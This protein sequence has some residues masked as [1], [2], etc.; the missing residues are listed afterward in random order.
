MFVLPPITGR[1]H[2]EYRTAI[3][4]SSITDLAA[5]LNKNSVKTKVI[6]KPRIAFL[7]TGQGSQY[8]GMGKEL[9]E[10][11]PGFRAIIDECDRIL[12]LYLEKPLLEILY[13]SS[14]D[15]SIN[16]TK[17]TQTAIFA[18]EYALCKLWQSWGIN[19]E[20]VMGHSVGEYV[21]AT[22][23]GVF[24]LEDGLKLIAARGKLMQTL[25]PGGMVAVKADI[26]RVEVA[27]E[28][29]VA[30]AAINGDKNIVISGTPEALKKVVVAL[31][32]EGIETSFLK[33]SRAFHSPLMKPILGEF[34]RIAG[35]ITYNLPRT[36]IVSNITGEI[37]N[38]AIA[39]PEYWCTHILKPVQFAAEMKTLQQAG[40]NV[41]VE[42]GAKPILLGMGRMLV[43]EGVW[44]PS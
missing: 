37:V 40:F 12:R 19:P 44:L 29:E 30:I 10:T 24:S 5:Q 4:A 22:I 15:T 33:V 3:V 43:D 18:L 23:A 14:S 9:Y 41:F 13:P 32:T 6:S 36:A 31:T 17:Y 11:Q 16:E 28:N 21:A 35:E 1:S 42:C 8:V 27:I 26:A 2:F 34:R 20:I 38:E 39:T 7:F 25:A